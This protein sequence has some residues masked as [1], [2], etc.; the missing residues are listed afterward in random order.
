MTPAQQTYYN[1]VLSKKTITPDEPGEPDEFVQFNIPTGDPLTTLPSITS[2]PSLGNPRL[3]IT[4]NNKAA[5]QARWNNPPTGKIA[6]AKTRILGWTSNP[7]AQA[8]AYQMTGDST[9][10]RNAINSAKSGMDSAWTAIKNGQMSYVRETYEEV[11][12]GAVA[13]SLCYNAFTGDS[14]RTEFASRLGELSNIEHELLTNAGNARDTLSGHKVEGPFGDGL[15]VAIA[16]AGYGNFSKY[17]QD[18]F[19]PHAQKVY[20]D[21]NWWLKNMFHHQGY[22]YSAERFIHFLHHMWVWKMLTGKDILS[23]HVLPMHYDTFYYTRADGRPFAL[24]D[25]TAPDGK[26][27]KH[28]AAN[29]LAATYYNDPILLKGVDTFSSRLTDNGG[30]TL[31]TAAQYENCMVFLFWPDEMPSTGLNG[32]SHIDLPK[33]KYCPGPLNQMI[34]FRTGWTVNNKLAS[35]ASVLLSIPLEVI[36]GHQQPYVS[37]NIYYKGLVAH[38]VNFYQANTN[39]KSDKS[40]VEEFLNKS[41]SKNG[42]PLIYKP[43]DLFKYQMCQSGANDGGQKFPIPEVYDPRWYPTNS[44]ASTYFTNDTSM[45]NKGNRAEHETESRAYIEVASNRTKQGIPEAV[46]VSTSL[47]CAYMETDISPGYNK[48]QYPEGEVKRVNKFNRSYVVAQTNDPTYPIVIF[49]IDKCDAVNTTNRKMN[50]FRCSATPSVSADNV[51]TASKTSDGDSGKVYKKVLYPYNVDFDVVDGYKMFGNNFN[52]S[53]SLNSISG[54]EQTV[55]FH[56]PGGGTVN[57][58]AYRVF[59]VG[60][61]D[62]YDARAKAEHGRNQVL[63]ILPTGSKYNLGIYCETVS[64]ASNTGSPT[65]EVLEDTTTYKICH[66]VGIITVVSNDFNLLTGTITYTAPTGAHRHIITNVAA[67]NWSVNGGAAIEAKAGENCLMFS[68]GAGTYTI[69]KV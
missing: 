17:Y 53:G 34:F 38:D 10:G 24:W 39:T 20:S 16:L 7:F 50:N 52:F 67:G 42:A 61:F 41:I 49:T 33:I 5:L 36:G 46:K 4:P 27:K 68:G 29:I 3:F 58:T 23:G 30:K 31:S 51:I 48:W 69:T 12:R 37:H 60:T 19:R 64:D 62:N 59:D 18:N 28:L 13:F 9:H 45:I 14:E 54:S 2:L 1:W 8:I 63:V 22:D 6:D 66:A 11:F 43:V 65:I 56:K 57:Y 47:M 40:P 35:E 32:S 26:Y 44:C 25:T 15:L 55:L 21:T